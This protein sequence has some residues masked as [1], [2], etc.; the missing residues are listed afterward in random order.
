MPRTL[1][2][3]EPCREPWETMTGTEARKHCARCEKHVVAL[4]E[5]EPEEA[6]RLITSAPSRSLCVRIEHDEHGE[7]Q[8]RTKG[9]SGSR[10][11]LRLAM[12]ASLLVAACGKPDAPKPSPDPAAQ[13]N[14]PT[15]EEKASRERAKAA[16]PEVVEVID[17]APQP[18]GDEKATP[19]MNGKRA[20]DQAEDKAKP[21]TYITAGCLCQPGD[22]LC[23]C[24]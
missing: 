10:P 17:D 9:S 7:V 23:A 20:T 4:A 21:K 12:S 15:A 5:M 24:L 16:W 14:E 11:M 13:T 1:H 3:A 2:I 22:P 19:G 8:F 6:E 18:S